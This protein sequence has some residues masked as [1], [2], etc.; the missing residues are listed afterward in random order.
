MIAYADTISII[1]RDRGTFIETV[2]R[3][4]EEAQNE[5]HKK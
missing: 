4:R 5:V 2:R 3:K 1:A